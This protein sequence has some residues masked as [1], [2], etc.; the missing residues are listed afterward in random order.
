MESS[1]LVNCMVVDLKVGKD[2]AEL[3][4]HDILKDYI[5]NRFQEIYEIKNSSKEIPISLLVDSYVIDLTLFISISSIIYEIESKDYFKGRLMDLIKSF[6]ELK[7]RKDLT[8][9]F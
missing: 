7:R 3:A 5:Q 6:P 8:N 4:N 9:L 2:L 1:E